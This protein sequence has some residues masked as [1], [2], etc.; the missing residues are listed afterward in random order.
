MMA[1]GARRLSH[2][3]AGALLQKDPVGPNVPDD[4]VESTRGTRTW[5]VDR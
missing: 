5:R 2:V 1:L 4:D 3:A